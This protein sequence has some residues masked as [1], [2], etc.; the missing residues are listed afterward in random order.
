MHKMSV[1]ELRWPG[2]QL[3][4]E[5]HIVAHRA[6]I[7]SQGDWHSACER[8][9]TSVPQWKDLTIPADP[10]MLYTSHHPKALPSI[11]IKQLM[12]DLLQHLIELE[13][14]LTYCIILKSPT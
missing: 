8:Y 9:G 4:T 3:A 11:G 14:Q 7:K 10:H 5:A 6:Y 12:K 13:E 2:K 1:L